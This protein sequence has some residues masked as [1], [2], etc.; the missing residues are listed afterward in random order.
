M[1][2]LQTAA[3]CTLAEQISTRL[4]RTAPH[5]QAKALH[6]LLQVG[7]NA[8]KQ[9][10]GRG[11]QTSQRSYGLACVHTQPLLKDCGSCAAG[12]FFWDGRKSRAAVRCIGRGQNLAETNRRLPFADRSY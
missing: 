12:G 9:I 7:F 4:S 5:S 3:A 10:S 11:A 8:V 2:I 6:D 1:T